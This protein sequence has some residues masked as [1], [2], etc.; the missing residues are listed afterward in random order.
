MIC[1]VHDPVKMLLAVMVVLMA[2]FLGTHRILMVQ[3]VMMV[4]RVVLVD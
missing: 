2:A 4:V 3:L 1:P